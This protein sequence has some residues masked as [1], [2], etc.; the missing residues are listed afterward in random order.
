MLFCVL[1][2]VVFCIDILVGLNHA[3]YVNELVFRSGVTIGSTDVLDPTAALKLPSTPYLENLATAV[4][5]NVPFVY[6]F[7]VLSYAVPY[8]APVN[9]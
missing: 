7:R 2:R 6:V 1:N 4:V 5:F 8:K 9:G 3:V